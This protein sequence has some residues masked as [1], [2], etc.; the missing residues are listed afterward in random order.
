MLRADGWLS[1][2]YDRAADGN[3]ALSAEI[4]APETEFILALG[5][6]RSAPEAAFRV[7]ASL[8]TPFD[9]LREEYAAGWRSWQ[10]RLR[11]LDRH[12]DT[13]NVYR[14]STAC[15]VATKVPPFPA[16]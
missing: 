4:A 12:V 10:A 1:T 11:S 9:A 5:F 2:E 7:R 6:G 3:V 13:H 14:V 15:C 8:Q 16:A